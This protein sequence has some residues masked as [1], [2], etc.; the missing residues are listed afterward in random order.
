MPSISTAR[1]ATGVVDMPRWIS[2]PSVSCRPMVSTGL[3][4]VIGSWKIMRD[5][6]APDAAHLVL[7]RA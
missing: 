3:S 4:E 5:L 2:R 1:S 6:A 7:A